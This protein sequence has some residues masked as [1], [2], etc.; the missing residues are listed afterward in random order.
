LKEIL[1]TIQFE[2]KHF[3]EFIEYCCEQFADNNEQRIYVNNQFKKKYRN[4]TAVWW[5]SSPSFLYPMV[6]TALRLMDV[7][8]IIKMGFFISDLHREIEQMHSKQ[9]NGYQS[10]TTFTVYRGQD[11]STEHF[12]QMKKAKGGL[13]TFNNFLSTSKVR[14]VALR[15]ARG[16]LPNPDLVG[17]LF[18]MTI[19]PSKSTTPFASINEVAYFKDKEDEILFSMNTVFRI[20][21]IKSMSENHRLYQVDLTLISDNDDDLCRL[22]DRVR[23]ETK[24][25]TGWDKMGDLLLKIGQAE[26]ALQIYEILLEQATTE[27]EKAQ[28]YHQLG[29]AKDDLEEYDEALTVYKKSLKIRQ[30]LLSSNHPDL[31]KSYNNIGVV[32]V[33]MGE[34]SK[35]LFSH[36]KALEI[37]QQS[38]S[39][40]HPHLGSS[41]NNIGVVYDKMGEYTEALSYYKKSLEIKQKSLPTHHPDLASSNNNIGLMYEHMG[42]YSKAHSFYQCA[43]DIAQ[44]SLPSN[45]PNQKNFRK[46]LDR[47]KKKL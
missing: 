9:F 27:I 11:M 45:H 14:D 35:A 25:S 44:N 43:V 46:N 19:D 33:N 16:A 29:R 40:N 4:E 6:N 24:G 36:E 28:I 13:L 34:Y 7:E 31:A 23:E 2:E 30:Q 47:V 1:L 42:N 18:V 15:F 20:R 21:G 37:R 39:P 5:Y 12:E 17:I 3:Q 38:L 41:Y 26:K 22:T 10:V 8:L 32:Y